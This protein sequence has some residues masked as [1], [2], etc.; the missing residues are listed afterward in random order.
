MIQWVNK[1]TQGTGVIHFKEQKMVGERKVREYQ[2][3]I[4]SSLDPLE[5]SIES[6]ILKL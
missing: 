2:F 6:V 4:S 1:S 3:I 5:Y